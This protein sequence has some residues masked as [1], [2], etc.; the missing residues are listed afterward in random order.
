MQVKGWT[1]LAFTPFAQR[2]VALRNEVASLRKKNPKG[3]ADHPTTKLLAS[4]YDTVT[5]SV[6]AN[7]NAAEFRLGKTLGSAHTAWRRVKNGLPN[8][9]H[10]FYRFSLRPAQL[11]IYV[12]LNDEATLRKEGAKTDVYAVFTAMLERGEVPES[13]AALQRAAQELI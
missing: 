5:R 7:P 2:L 9:H 8:R 11:V 1:L 13:I 10:L 4:V 6:P 12:W 3:F